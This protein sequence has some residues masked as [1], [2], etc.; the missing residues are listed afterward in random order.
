MFGADRPIGRPS[1]YVVPV[2]TS[3]E[4]ARVSSAVMRFTVPRWSSLPHRPQLLGIPGVAPETLPLS[5]TTYDGG[6]QPENGVSATLRTDR[7][8]ALQHQV[9]QR[10]E[11]ASEFRSVVDH[12][13]VMCLRDV[14]VDQG[15]CDVALD[16]FDLGLA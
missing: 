14:D 5:S 11:R 6:V 1:G 10:L 8:G 4:A 13:M 16:G 15:G 9:D 7:S 12:H 3:R 2:L